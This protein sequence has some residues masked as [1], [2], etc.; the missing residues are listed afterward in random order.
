MFL[1]LT[2]KISRKA[3]KTQRE[4]E[5]KLRERETSASFLLFFASSPLCVLAALREQ[6][7]PILPGPI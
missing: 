1:H 2:L 6:P 3:A 7:A 5:K 4:E